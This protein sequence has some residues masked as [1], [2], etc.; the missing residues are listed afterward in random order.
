[1]ANPILDGNLADWT[2]ADR[3]ETAATTIAGYQLYG[4]YSDG[5]FFFALQSALAIGANTTL[6]LN[7]DKSLDTGYK[8][9]GFAAGAEFNVN[10]GADG[11]PRLYTGADGQTL[12]GNLTYA[13]SAEHKTLEI[14]LPKSL[15]G[16][17][18]TCVDILADVNNSVFLPGDYTQPAYRIAD[19]TVIPTG[20][21]DGLLTEWT[22]AQRLDTDAN[23]VAGYEVYGKVSNDSFVFGVK[24]AVAIGAN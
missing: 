10:F 9:W 1:M 19:L 2:S 5:V 7:T 17:A 13:L 11:V 6:W 23:G 15:L 22:Q 24:S 12:V 21:Y 18:V 3:L 14:A 16:A 4:R 8:V 20:P